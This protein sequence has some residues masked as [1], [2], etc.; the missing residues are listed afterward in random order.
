M[1]ARTVAITGVG[2]FIGQHLAK[3]HMDEMRDRVIGIDRVQP[4]NYHHC[5]RFVQGDVKSP[6]DLEDLFQQ[7]R[8]DVVYH[9]A[10]ALGPDRVMGNPT[11]TVR[12]NVEGV[13]TL[14]QVIQ[15]RARTSQ[16]IAPPR[17]VFTSTSEVYGKGNQLP[18][19]ENFDLV[20]GSS[21]NPR[22][23]YAAS[24]IAG[25][26]LV[27]NSG[28]GVVARIFNTSGPGQHPGYVVPTMVDRASKGQSI[29][30]HG[31]GSQTRCFCHVEDTVKGLVV[32]GMAYSIQGG[33]YNIGSD[34]EISVLE[35]AELVRQLVA[36][37]D[38][39]FTKDPAGASEMV[40]RVPGLTRIKG[41]GWRYTK[42][43]RDIITDVA[44]Q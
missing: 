42:T 10:A 29:Q 16:Q 39:E 14:L 5:H 24:K 30:V 43:I 38:L 20:L 19:K 17:L 36:P 2:G 18:Y 7:E 23:S 40:R 11:W 33:I 13:L 31:D 37:V 26:H 25:E 27:L 44:R 41:L 35:L 21:Y 1:V 12:E 8:V 15:E 4:A 3:Y 9:L 28:I 22:W 6:L 34:Q 32:L